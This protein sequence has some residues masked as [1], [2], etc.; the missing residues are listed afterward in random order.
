MCFF[1]NP[2]GCRVAVMTFN[3]ISRLEFDFLAS[4]DMETTAML[5]QDVVHPGY[6]GTATG[7]GMADTASWLLRND[8][9]GWRRGATV[10]IVV[11]DGNTQETVLSFD[12]RRA[13]LV[14]T[15]AAISAVG[16]GPDVTA[17]A[18]STRRDLDDIPDIQRDV[19]CGSVV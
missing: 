11:T 5:L 10:V 1:F 12:S 7:R 19:L 16:I 4:R 18:N 14:R 2:V 9:R 8:T 6:G 17:L 15:G 3:T 13:Q